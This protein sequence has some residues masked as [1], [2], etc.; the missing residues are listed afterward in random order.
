[1]GF[2]TRLVSITT[3]SFLKHPPRA[4][5]THLYWVPLVTGLYDNDPVLSRLTDIHKLVVDIDGTSPSTA[6][7]RVTQAEWGVQ[8]V[9]YELETA[10]LASGIT[11]NQ[12][13]RWIVCSVTFFMKH[14]ECAQ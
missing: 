13:G 1:M 6:D 3:W 5:N 14:Q 12:T 2:C 11:P 9:R 8:V 7:A 4:P 10:K